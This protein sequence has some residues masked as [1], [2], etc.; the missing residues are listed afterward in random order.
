MQNCTLVGAIISFMK[1]LVS[2]S[3][4]YWWVKSFI[5]WSLCL[6]INRL[7]ASSK[8]STHCWTQLI[9]AAHNCHKY[10]RKL[11]NSPLVFGIKFH[12]HLNFLKL[13]MAF[14][15]HSG[16]YLY[17]NHQLSKKENKFHISYLFEDKCI[18]LF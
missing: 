7:S 3:V 9:I 11:K 6:K 5:S 13:L 2:S 8:Q 1:W 14:Y 17:G 18:G 16:G 4:A 15:Y 12:A 10:L